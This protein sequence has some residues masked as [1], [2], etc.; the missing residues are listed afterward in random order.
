MKQIT[1]AL[2]EELRELM[3]E[4]D[5]TAEWVEDEYPDCYQEYQRWDE[6]LGQLT[7]KRVLIERGDR[8]DQ[9]FRMKGIL[10]GS[11]YSHIIIKGI[12]ITEDEEYGTMGID[13]L[14]KPVSLTILD[15]EEK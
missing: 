7:G 2:S 3:M 6:L 5:V 9:L 11:T 1:I 14:H 13:F 8:E 15:E 12:V 10:K 4:E